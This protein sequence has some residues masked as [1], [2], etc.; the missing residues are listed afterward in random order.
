MASNGAYV[1]QNGTLETDIRYD[2]IGKNSEVIAAG[3]VLTIASGLVKVVAAATDPILGVATKT[4]TMASN[5]QTVAPIIYP[6]YIPAENSV[7]FMYTNADLTGNATNGGTYY[8]L[9]GGTGAVVVDVN[10]G[11]T[12][13]TSKQVEIVKVD[14]RNIGGTGAGSG[15]RECLVKFVRTPST[16]SNA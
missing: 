7:F 3:D 14:P 2:S 1:Y 10:G 6:G 9:T 13:T 16:I 8:G 12:S 15:L 11:V 5:N 4:A